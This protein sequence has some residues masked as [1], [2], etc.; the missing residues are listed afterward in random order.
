MDGSA[1]AGEDYISKNGLLEFAPNET[2]KFVQ[3]EVVDDISH[4]E[5][6]DFFVTLSNL[7]DTGDGPKGRCELFNQKATVVI[8]DD[9]Y[10]GI[11]KFE[12]EQKEIF[13]DVEN[14]KFILT[15]HRVNG[16]TGKVGCKYT[17][18]DGTAIRGADYMHAQGTLEFDNQV[19][20]QQIELEVISRG[21]YE[22]DEEFRVILSDAFGGAE[23]DESTDG[24]KDSCICTIVVKP[25]GDMKEGTARMMDALKVNWD[26][27]QL[28]HANYASQFRDA[29]AIGGDDEDEGASPGPLDYF[30]HIITVPWKLLFASVPP[31]D[32][33]DG[34]LCFFCALSMIGG[35]TY[36]VGAL[37][38]FLGCCMGIADEITAITFVALGT[39]LPDTFASKTAAVMDEYADA[40]IGNVTG[41]NSVN[42]FLGLGLPWMIGAIYWVATGSNSDWASRY[43]VEAAEYP[44]GIFVVP[45]G[46]LSFNVLVFT[47]LACVAMLFLFLR[48]LSVGGE[49]GGPAAHK[50][51]SAAFLTMLW[52]IYIALSVW[53]IVSEPKCTQLV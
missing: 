37:A 40:S 26:K 48:R 44:N 35:V 33:A 17:T 3:V 10:P 47:V 31:V 49:L 46:T 30:L 50:Y 1:K 38:T 28:G 27:S 18:E 39:S 29:I 4:E 5:D 2:E 7:I 25:N 19:M 42:V 13:E 24:A 36:V 22:R 8:I 9:D 16:S 14:T 45:A 6:E 12:V 23:F 21:R 53:K 15:V 43:P 51:G 32:Y 52:L 11:L 34:W 41:S 20:S